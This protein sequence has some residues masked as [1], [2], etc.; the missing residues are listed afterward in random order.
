L[1]WRGDDDWFDGVGRD[2][3]LQD[4]IRRGLR[5]HWDVAVV[6]GDA[7]KIEKIICILIFFCIF[8]VWIW[9]SRPSKK[10]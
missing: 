5:W 9:C 3:P 10:I 6:V 7:K 2:S 1:A 4:G 8:A